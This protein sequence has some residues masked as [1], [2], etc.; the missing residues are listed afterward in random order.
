MTVIMNTYAVTKNQS[1]RAAAKHTDAAT[2]ASDSYSPLFF[3]F[4]ARLPF[5]SSL[6]ER[7]SVRIVE[8]LEPRLR[9]EEVLQVLLGEGTVALKK[10]ARSASVG[11][12][13][14]VQSQNCCAELC[15]P[16]SGVQNLA[17]DTKKCA[18]YGANNLC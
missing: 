15:A 12:A 1:D 17:P 10:R 11:I 9:L 7:S 13:T 6:A 5:R 2:S 18:M 16:G 3:S 4:D 8:P 14:G